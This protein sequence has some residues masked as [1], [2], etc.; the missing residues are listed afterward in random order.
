MAGCSSILK[1]MICTL[2]WCSGRGRMNLYKQVLIFKVFSAVSELVAP[3]IVCTDSPLE[4]RHAIDAI[5]PLG[6]TA[7]HGLPRCNAPQDMPM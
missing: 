4:Y 5:D 3:S 1:I 6:R 7:P 2:P